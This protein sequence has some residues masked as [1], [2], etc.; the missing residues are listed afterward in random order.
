MSARRMNGDAPIAAA[1][2]AKEMGCSRFVMVSAHDYNLPEP[3]KTQLM[4]SYFQ[5]KVRACVRLRD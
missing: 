3:L 5:P 4:G 1:Q 2:L